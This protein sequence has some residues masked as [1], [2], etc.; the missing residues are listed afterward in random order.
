MNFGVYLSFPVSGTIEIQDFAGTKQAC[1]DVFSVG[2][3]YVHFPLL[4]LAYT[5]YIKVFYC[6]DKTKNLT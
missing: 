4:A 6:Y 5:E 1:F 2:C 3:K